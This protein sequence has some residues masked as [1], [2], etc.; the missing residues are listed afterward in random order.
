MK[1]KYHCPSFVDGL[2]IYRELLIFKYYHPNYFYDNFYIETIFGH[3]PNMVWGGGGQVLGEM[4]EL[5]DV[6]SI[7]KFYNDMSIGL[8]LTMT[9]PLLEKTDVYDR[10]CNAI[11]DRLLE[12]PLNSVLVSS[13]C[14][15]NYIRE[16]HPEAK[17]DLSI[18]ATTNPKNINK[19][20]NNILENYN[21]LV[22]PR[23]YIKD[24][25]YLNNIKEEYR[26]KIELL[27]NDPCP[28]DCPRLFSH[29]CDHA[30][31]NLYSTSDI[32]CPCTYVDRNDLTFFQ[33]MEHKIFYNDFQ[34][35]QDV[36]YNHF[37]ISGRGDTLTTI[38][39]IIPYMVKPEYQLEVAFYILKK[40]LR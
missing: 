38:N 17:I 26:D 2:D 7:F 14:L 29:Y 21:R 28:I 1:Y 8:Q 16:K 36:G 39:C 35:Y 4:V 33:N 27:C 25:N 34:S 20:F 10:Y 3:F 9:N 19:D 18:I 11:L 13:P 22:L 24:F 40:V 37:K 12:Y 32:Y 6:E 23:K 5:K 31:A 30:K 15:E